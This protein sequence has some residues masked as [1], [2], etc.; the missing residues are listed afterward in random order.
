MVTAT[1]LLVVSWTRFE[2]MEEKTGDWL[3][4]E[5]GVRVVLVLV[6]V[7]CWGAAEE[8]VDVGESV[9]EVDWSTVDTAVV[10][11]TTGGGVVV[12]VGFWALSWREKKR[13]RREEKK[14]DLRVIITV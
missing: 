6:L 4:I 3:G 2:V 13:R 8:G 14:V 9:L 12:V 11:E 10:V 7:G 1:P 5:V